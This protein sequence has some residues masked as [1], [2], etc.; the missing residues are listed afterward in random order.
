MTTRWAYF[1]VSQSYWAPSDGLGGGRW[2]FHPKLD[3]KTLPEVFEKLG[4]DRWELVT[5]T[6][7]TDWVSHYFK[8]PVL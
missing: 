4:L 8:R 5:S 6:S 2:D 3:C 1:T 7:G